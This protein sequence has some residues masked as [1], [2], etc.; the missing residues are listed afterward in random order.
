MDKQGYREQVKKKIAKLS[1]KHREQQDARVN[2]RVC[3]LIEQRN[4]HEVLLYVALPDE[5]DLTATI[6]SCLEQ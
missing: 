3:D 6:M 4:P 2:A 1:P 5:V